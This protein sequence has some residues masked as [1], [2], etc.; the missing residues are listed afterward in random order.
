MKIEILYTGI[1]L[2]MLISCASQNEKTKGFENDEQIQYEPTKIWFDLHLATVE[3][4]QIKDSLIVADTTYW[5]IYSAPFFFRMPGFGNNSELTLSN[6]PHSGQTS[7][8]IYALG[9]AI[10]GK[11]VDFGW[12]INTSIGDTLWKMT[13]ENTSYAG[14]DERNRKFE[15]DLILP[16]GAYQLHYSTNE[17]H[18]S[19]DGWTSAPPENPDYWGVLI[20]RV[21]VVKKIKNE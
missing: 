21:D 16:P 3:E 8:R 2:I 5:G 10:N 17:S 12:L 20:Y 9:E 18:S 19:N 15:G 14:G 13:Y 6:G 1:S 11:M 4:D 7:V